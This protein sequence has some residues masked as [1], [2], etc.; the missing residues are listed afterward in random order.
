MFLT[1]KKKIV[2]RRRLF[3]HPKV[4]TLNRKNSLHSKHCNFKSTMY[5][6]MYKDRFSYINKQ[7]TKAAG[8]NKVV[9]LRY[10]FK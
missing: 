7:G 1:K 10:C 6:I 3:L 2:L 4:G 9:S 5:K 8:I